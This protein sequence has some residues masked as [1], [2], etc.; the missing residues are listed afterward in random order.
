MKK[1]TF[2][3][4]AIALLGLSSLDASAQASTQQAQTP[5]TQEQ[6]EK[7]EKVTQDQLPE[8]V[9]AALQSD[10]YKDWTVG[11][12]HKVVPATG[13]T[14]GSAV[15]EVTMTNAEGQ[16]GVVRMNEKGG[17]ASKD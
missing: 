2:L 9:K 4:A 12:I 13:E 1:T 6:E 17:D 8:P 7:K 5:V 14:E 3:A 11:E 10:T 15:Y 16:T